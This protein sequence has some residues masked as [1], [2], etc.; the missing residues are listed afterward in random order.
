MAPQRADAARAA[1][2]KHKDRLLGL[3]G[4]TGIFTGEKTTGG[5]KTGQRSVVV[6]VARKKPLPAIP[7]DARIPATLDG[8]PTDVIEE[9][10]RPCDDETRYDPLVG[11]S[12]I[13]VTPDI[14]D[15][16][17]AGTAGMVVRDSGTRDAM[18]LSCW[19]VLYGSG[20]GTD[21]DV[22][23]NPPYAGGD[24]TP[25]KVGTTTRFSLSPSVDG[26][27][28]RIEGRDASTEILE[29]GTPTA[30]GPASVGMNVQKRGKASGLTAGTVTA[31]DWS[32]LI[33][34]GPP[35]G[36]R[37][38]SNMIRFEGGAG[39]V[40]G[41]DS[42][43]VIVAG[44]DGGGG[45]GDGGCVD[46]VGPD[47]ES[48][49]LT[50]FGT[51]ISIAG[52]VLN[53]NEGSSA[54]NT[55]IAIGWGDDWQLTAVVEGSVVGPGT[56][57]PWLGIVTNTSFGIGAE[58]SM[59]DDG[60]S[61]QVTS[62]GDDFDTFSAPFD[63]ESPMIWTL[64]RLGAWVFWSITQGSNHWAGTLTWGTPLSEDDPLALRVYSSNGSMQLDSAQYCTGSGIG[65]VL[66]VAWHAYYGGWS[67]VDPTEAH[68]AG[69]ADEFCSGSPG[70]EYSGFAYAG[71]TGTPFDGSQ[72]IRMSGHVELGGTLS[73]AAIFIGLQDATQSGDGSGFDWATGNS[74]NSYSWVGFDNDTIDLTIPFDFSLDWNPGASTFAVVL[75][76]PAGP[77]VLASHTQ[78]LGSW[79]VAA[80]LPVFQATGN[81]CAM[82]MGVTDIV[83]VVG[84]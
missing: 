69:A 46:A 63:V 44:G 71:G 60:A 76:D 61:F 15:S 31:T 42:G 9:V 38:F 16:F 11:G 55:A 47:D 56:P 70:A 40:L 24:P 7:A 81:H 54:I 53:A 1:T 78:A 65:A 48:D 68:F 26:A 62:N 79:P 30:I 4:V 5:K 57:E 67:F 66:P 18:I 83:V 20:I 10:F 58:I 51:A 64:S 6:S 73:D 43:S 75:T 28:A 12:S 52:G 36:V 45:G 72:R 8:I 82:S 27:V 39:M 21:G 29:I 23:T 49:W 37:S 3:P 50:D 41:G 32:G 13:S 35:I 14:D 33:D 17:S 84:G 25:N 19:H 80:R 74:V 59:W 34:Y 22:V 77:T 2:A